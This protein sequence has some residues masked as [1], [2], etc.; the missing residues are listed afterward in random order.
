MA[1][2]ARIGL[3][4]DGT[5][6]LVWLVRNHLLLADTATRRDLSDERTITRF[7]RAVGDSERLDLLYPLTI[8]DSRATGS[9]AWS[10][11]KAALVRELFVKTDALF[12]EGV[13][14]LETAASRDEPS[15]RR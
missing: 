5:D 3:D 2:A 9:A 1:V 11:S 8:G 14:G 13:V 7:A 12:D 4:D 15:W 6:E 10:T